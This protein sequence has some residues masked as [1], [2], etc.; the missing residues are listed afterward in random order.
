MVCSTQD[1]YWTCLGRL[2]RVHGASNRIAHERASCRNRLPPLS[3]S[4]NQQAQEQAPT[5]PE[6]TV[7]NPK[8]PVS[9]LAPASG[10]SAQA[11]TTS[12][13]IANDREVS[14]PALTNDS[15]IAATLVQLQ[16][17]G[18]RDDCGKAEHGSKPAVET[19]KDPKRLRQSNLRDFLRGEKI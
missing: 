15:D 12:V 7:D 14:A 2:E 18:N 10:V 19:Q 9:Q 11:P 16:S 6:T 1:G 5:V 4:I 3:L 17:E 8:V 13:S